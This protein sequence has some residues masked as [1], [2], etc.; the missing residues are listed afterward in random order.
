MK[1][2]ILKDNLNYPKCMSLEYRSIKFEVFYDENSDT[3]DCWGN[4]DCFVV[5]DYRNGFKTAKQELDIDYIRRSIEETK[6][7]FV[8]GYWIFPVSIYDH[9]G[10]ALSLNSSFVEDCGNWDTSH[11]FAFACVKRQ[12][13]WSYTRNKAIEIAEECI[14]EWNDYLS[15][16]VFGF[17]IDFGETCDSCGGYPGDDGKECCISEAESIIDGYIERTEAEQLKRHIAK[18]KSQIKGHAPLSVRKD[19]KLKIG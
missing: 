12:K 11:G 17:Y 7:M 9:S 15:G 19:F 16:E 14:K 4:D 5:G 18:R 1:S 6:R 13:G 10:I 8:D 3:P 2:K